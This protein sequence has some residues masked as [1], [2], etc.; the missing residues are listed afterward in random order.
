MTEYKVPL[1]IRGTV[2]ESDLVEFGGRGGSAAFRTPDVRKHVDALCLRR[3]SDLADLYSIGFDEILSYLDELGRRLRLDDNPHLQQACELSTQTSGLGREMI[4]EQYDSFHQGCAA[5]KVR[6][7][8][9]LAIGVPYLEGWVAKP[10]SNGGV[11]HVRAF[12]ART[13]HILAGNV[14]SGALQT[15]VRNAVTRSDAIIKAPS[16]DPLTAAA[17][18]RTMVAMAPGHPLT[19]HVS[20]GYWKGGDAAVEDLLYQPHNIEK[21]MAWGGFS[22]I[23][24]I[25]KYIQPGIDLITMDP[26]L[27]SS[28]IGREAFESETTMLAVAERLAEDVA[29]YNQEGCINSRVSYVETGTDAA[30]LERAKAFGTMVHDAIQRLPVTASCPARALSPTLADE[31]QAL[32]L[33]GDHFVIGCGRE[34]GVIVSPGSDPVEFSRLLAHR[35]ANLVPVDDMEVP[36]RSINA[37]TQTI[38]IYPEALKTAIRDRCVFHGAQRLVSLGYAARSAHAGPHDGIEPLR[39]MCKWITDETYDPDRV[40]RRSATAAVP[41]EQA[42]LVA[43]AS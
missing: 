30:G 5:D 7:V 39:R 43:Q 13:V 31:I 8:V 23:T 1:I 9:E 10:V 18:V 27:S 41:L 14:P 20:L 6:E 2:I 35:I 11:A 38:G 32:R 26:K 33:F 37:Y 42:P 12:G 34:G 19:R 40:P 15:I 29:Y 22:S 17:I 3:S 36:I 4:R 24:H 16:N 28:I 21:I 25:Q